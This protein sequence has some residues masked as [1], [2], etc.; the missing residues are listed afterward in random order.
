MV[1]DSLLA[2]SPKIAAAGASGLQI[3]DLDKGFVK[4]TNVAAI[5]ASSDYLFTS[6]ESSRRN[7]NCIIIYDIDNLRPVSEI[8]HYEIFGAELDSAIPST[9]LQWIS[10]HNLLMASGS[11]SGP[12]G[13]LGRKSIVSQMLEF[14]ILCLRCS[15]LG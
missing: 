3:L 5:G 6:F 4:E 8:G 7:S 13:V 15:K 14:R 11:H 1:F 12:A 2:L 10:S 9:K